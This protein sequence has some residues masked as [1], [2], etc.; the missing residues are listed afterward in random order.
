MIHTLVT[1]LGKGKKIES[2]YRYPNG[3]ESKPIK[4]FGW[5]LIARCAASRVVILGTAG[6][7]WDLLAELL[8]ETKL[9]DEGYQ[10]WESIEKAV[11]S[12]SVSDDLLRDFNGLFANSCEIEVVMKIIPVALTENDQLEIL[13]ILA[14]ATTNCKKLTLDVSHSF[15]HL[16]MLAMVACVY[17]QSIRPVEVTGFWYA[18]YDPEIETGVVHSLKG[19]LTLFDWVVALSKHEVSGDYGVFSN[20]L[21]NIKDF[22]STSLSLAA[23]YERNNLDVLAEE[24]LRTV[25]K[26]LSEKSL[27]GIGG[28]FQSSIQERLSWMREQVRENRQQELAKTYMARR[29]YVRA[30]IFA[31]EAFI[32]KLVN[33]Y[34]DDVNKHRD[35]N[36]AKY[37]FENTQDVPEIYKRIRNFRNAIAHGTKPENS[38]T[39]KMMKNE[40]QLSEALHEFLRYTKNFKLH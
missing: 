13:R 6:S 23:Y 16:P 33:L 21:G 36:A 40:E 17:L 26:L 27:D 11:E 31:Y 15:R 4:F 9:D 32:T 14:E 1:F 28:L 7:N 30:S 25:N 2:V 29:D 5:D 34:G 20:L 10:K 39:L 3:E 37:E 8:D 24:K 22:D 18:Y 19:L 12:E 35:R 38:D